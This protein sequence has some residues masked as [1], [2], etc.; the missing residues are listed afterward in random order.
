[1]AAVSLPGCYEMPGGA[2]DPSLALANHGVL[3]SE[4][5]YAL[6]TQQE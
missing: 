2:A 6:G 3:M 1:M 4:E 5:D